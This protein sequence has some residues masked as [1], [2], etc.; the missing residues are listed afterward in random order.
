VKVIGYFVLSKLGKS[1]K[2]RRMSAK[3]FEQ[4]KK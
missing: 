2:I 4:S 1:R 3:K